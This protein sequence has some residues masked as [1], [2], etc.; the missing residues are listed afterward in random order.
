MKPLDTP[1]GEYEKFF[2]LETHVAN[3]CVPTVAQHSRLGQGIV[4]KLCCGIC[5]GPTE[6]AAQCESGDQAQDCQASST[7][8]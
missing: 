8:K 1:T 6:V 7:R 5:C 2:S 3:A 4:R